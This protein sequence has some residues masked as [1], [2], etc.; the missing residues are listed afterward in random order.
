[1]NAVVRW[2]IENWVVVICVSLP[3]VSLIRVRRLRARGRLPAAPTT[4]DA[5]AARFVS[6]RVRWGSEPFGPF[7][8]MGYGMGLRVQVTSDAAWIV[9]M[10][11]F[12]LL[13]PSH[14]RRIPLDAI[15]S[16]HRA[17]NCVT[18][19]GPV[20]GGRMELWFPRTETAE[21]LVGV[22]RAAVARESTSADVEPG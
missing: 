16:V 8:S 20:P 6:G 22:L 12:L 10:Q 5:F 19:A 7:G 18:I 21:R 11:P 15:E 1:M 13:F 4:A 2:V 14:I 17:A 3:L 9:P